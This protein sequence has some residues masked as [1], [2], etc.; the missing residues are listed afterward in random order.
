MKDTAYFV[1]ILECSDGTYYTGIAKELQ[2][3]V[4]EHNGAEKGAKYTRT[5]RPVALAYSKKCKDK[6]TA[7]KREIEIKKLTRKEKT[8]LITTYN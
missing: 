6:G 3:R 2:K 7:L 8:K 4:G 1:Y 5:R